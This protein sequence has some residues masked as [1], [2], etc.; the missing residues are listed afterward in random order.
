[1]APFLIGDDSLFIPDRGGGVD[2][3]GADQQFRLKLLILI[4]AWVESW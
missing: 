2:V 4:T 3:D 1:V